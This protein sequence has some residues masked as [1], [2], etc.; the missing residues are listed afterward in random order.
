MLMIIRMAKTNRPTAK[1]PP[2]RKAPKA[3][4][5]LP[6]AASPSCPWTSTTRVDATFNARR[7]RV[8]NRRTVGKAEKSSGFLAF[9]AT[10][11]MAT[12]SPRLN[13]KNT[14]SSTAGTGTTISR[15][16]ARMPAG[17]T[18]PRSAA[19]EN[20]PL[21]RRAPFATGGPV[22]KRRGG[23]PDWRL[24]EPVDGAAMLRAAS[25]HS[26][27]A[28]AG[29]AAKP[30]P[31]DPT[32]APAMPRAM[33]ASSRPYTSPRLSDRPPSVNTPRLAAAA[34]GNRAAAE[35]S[36]RVAAATRNLAAPAG[37]RKWAR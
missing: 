23:S 27:R 37:P 28:S 21:T 9:K 31:P 20:S 33:R 22:P 8:A 1:L 17:S 10:I 5:T 11:R 14:S 12:D 26:V 32:P 13:T 24:N 25:C 7:N 30:V 18:P 35:A 29:A 3:S 4:I 34:C 2:I 15:I 19:T 6:A 36:G 16:R